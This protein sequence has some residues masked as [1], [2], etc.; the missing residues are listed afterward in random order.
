M[1]KFHVLEQ[2]LASHH[3]VA[4]NADPVDPTQGQASTACSGACHGSGGQANPPTD[5]TGHTT[6]SSIGVGAHEAHVNASDWHKRVECGSCHKV[7]EQIGDPELEVVR[8][9]D[10]L[11]GGEPASASERTAADNA[12][13][14]SVFVIGPD[15]RIK[16]ALTY[17]MTTGR[18]FVEILRL[19]D[20][21]RLTAE[22]Q[23]ATP[24]NWQHGDPVIIVPSVSDEQAAERYPDGW[25]AR[26]PYLRYVKLSVGV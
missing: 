22:Q 3:S 23:L 16:A 8:L 21:C 4:A 20:S 17:P 11:P 9:Y 24:A 14:R 1:S 19:I 12:T 13:A 26:L 15:K 6:P 18:N 5:T 2:E 10:M 7:P 25:E